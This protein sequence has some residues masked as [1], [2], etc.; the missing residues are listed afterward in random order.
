[1]GKKSKTTSKIK[2]TKKPGGHGEEDVT[3][4]CV[5]D[6]FDYCGNE[7]KVCLSELGWDAIVLP[8]IKQNSFVS[9]GED[10]FLWE[11]WGTTA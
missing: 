9:G 8:L 5:K 4:I 10:G 7:E 3:K 6:T 11:V 1:M 2:N